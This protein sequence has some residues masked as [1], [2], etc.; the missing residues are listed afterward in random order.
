MIQNISSEIVFGEI[1][2]NRNN[3]LEVFTIPYENENFEM[4]LVI[5]KSTK[6][7]NILENQMMLKDRQDDQASFEK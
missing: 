6:G 1:T 5:P 3:F 4:Q 2:T 7:L